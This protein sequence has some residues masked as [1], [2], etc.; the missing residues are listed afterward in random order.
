MQAFQEWGQSF[1]V[2]VSNV[3]LPKHQVQFNSIFDP[4][5]EEFK[6]EQ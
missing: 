6:K 4:Q 2:K 1:I 5:D 3:C